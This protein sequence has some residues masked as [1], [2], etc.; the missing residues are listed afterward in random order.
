VIR[1][2]AASAAMTAEISPPVVARTSR[3]ASYLRPESSLVHTYDELLDDFTIVSLSA[4]AEDLNGRGRAADITYL[5]PG[6][7]VPGDATVAMIHADLL[8]S[9]AATAPDRGLFGVSG[10]RIVDAADLASSTF[11]S[12]FERG[13]VSLNPLVPLVVTNWYGDDVVTRARSVLEHVYGDLSHLEPTSSEELLVAPLDRLTPTSSP[14]ELE[15]IVARL[16]RPDGC[17]WDREQTRESL[18]PQFREELD[19]LGDAIAAG[20][21]RNQ[22]EELGDVLFHVIAQCQIAHERGDFSLDDVVR[23]ITA[24]LIRRHPHVFGD[25]VVESID[26]VL[27]TWTRVKAEEK[28]DR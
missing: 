12:P 27:R 25:E 3:V 24:K 1:V 9:I 2:L 19:E 5:V 15:H 8:G 23:E 11:A 28:S 17:P 16:R 7:A 13:I 14:G 20:D 18:L 6:S 26:D 22:Q 4:I 21:V 10:C